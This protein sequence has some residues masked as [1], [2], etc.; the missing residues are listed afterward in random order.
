MLHC[1]GNPTRWICA[2]LTMTAIFAILGGM[3]MDAQVIADTGREAKDRLGKAAYFWAALKN[4]PRRHAHV[5]I[6]LD[7]GRPFRRKAKSVLLANMGQIYRRR[8]DFSPQR[9]RVTA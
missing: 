8:L 9:L 2:G 7:G 6:S 1:L 4:L 5:H 3:G